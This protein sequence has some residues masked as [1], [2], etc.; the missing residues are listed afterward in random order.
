MWA[1]QAPSTQRCEIGFC[2]NAYVNVNYDCNEFKESKEKKKCVYMYRLITVCS[3][4]L[5]VMCIYVIYKAAI[6]SKIWASQAKKN[7]QAKLSKEAVAVKRPI[8]LDR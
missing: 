2:V 3:H 4:Y 5:A 8:P 7:S 1:Q 6:S